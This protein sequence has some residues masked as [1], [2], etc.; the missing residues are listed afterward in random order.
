MSQLFVNLGVIGL[1]LFSFVWD[2]F[3]LFS[4]LDSS[5]KRF[6][7][8]DLWELRLHVKAAIPA[9]F[10]FGLN[11]SFSAAIEPQ[12]LN[13]ASPGLCG[14]SV[15]TKAPGGH[16]QW[17][18]L[19]KERKTMYRTPAAHL[20]IYVSIKASS[21]SRPKAATKMKGGTGQKPQAPEL[22]ASGLSGSLESHSCWGLTSSLNHPEHS[23]PKD[24]EGSCPQRPTS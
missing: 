23:P 14:P 5:S 8:L 19:G 4:S 1:A 11:S 3:S 13:E 10:N 22:K 24:E 18:A 20:E 2:R 6:S 9:T 21:T 7:C 16:L 17:S 12:G 15:P